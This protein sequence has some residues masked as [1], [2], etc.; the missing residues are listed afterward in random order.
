MRLK[1]ISSTKETSHARGVDL[2]VKGEL[3]DVRIGN[4]WYEGEGA[5]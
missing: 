3:Y 5:T 1:N 4:L 2:G